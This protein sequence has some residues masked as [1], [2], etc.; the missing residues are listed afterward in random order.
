MKIIKKGERTEC[1]ECHRT[2]SVTNDVYGCDTCEKQIDE[3][4]LRVFVFSHKGS[5]ASEYRFCSWACVLK[6]LKTLKSDYFIDLPFL[7][8]DTAT[9]GQHARDFF[10]AIKAFKG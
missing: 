8:F 2:I 10:A 6:K 3:N 9:K 1:G 7:H 4:A 5:G